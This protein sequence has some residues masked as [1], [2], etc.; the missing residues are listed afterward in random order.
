MTSLS[1]K[2]NWPE[3]QAAFTRWWNRDGMLI[4]LTANSPAPRKPELAPDHPSDITTTWLDPVYRRKQAEHDLSRTHFLAEA[5]PI[6]DTQIGP[7][8]LSTFLGARPEFAVDT[9]WYWP[10]IKDPDRYGPIRFSAENNPW[11]DAHLA[12]V[13]EGIKHTNGRYLVSIPDMI[14]NLDTLASLRG[15]SLLLFDMIERPAWVIEKISEINQAYFAAFD[16]IFDRVKDEQGGCVFSAFRVW[17]PGKTAKIQCDISA[18]ISAKM[19]RK[20]VQPGLQEQVRWLDFSIY[21]LDGTTCFQHIDPLLEIDGL[22]AIEWTPQ[23]GKPGGGSPEWFDLYRRIKA[24]G[25]SVQCIGVEDEEVIPLLDAIGPD[26]VYILL[27]DRDRTLDQAE[28]LLK[29]I[30][31]YRK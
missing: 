28:A 25:K 22:N 18:T 4:Y 24:G 10:C 19:F 27:N 15:D 11:L 5:I 8:S 6:F 12:L 30:E 26:G 13:D 31:A 21:H 23:A 16:L 9:V 3:T 2:P 29:S 17:G 1:W 14:E 20:F 7:G